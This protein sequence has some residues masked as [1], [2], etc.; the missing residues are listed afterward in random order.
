EA[1]AQHW[2]EKDR[3][4]VKGM[5]R[6]EFT[7]IMHEALFLLR[8]YLGM[9]TLGTRKEPAVNKWF[10]P[11][12]VMQHLSKL[13]EVAHGTSKREDLLDLDELG[14]ELFIGRNS[15]S[16]LVKLSSI[17]H[18]STIDDAKLIE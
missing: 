9:T 4:R 14:S 17:P 8:D 11:S 3:P 12:L 7:G 10:Y 18:I 13:I 2:W 6:K 16:H 5:E 15:A 1:K